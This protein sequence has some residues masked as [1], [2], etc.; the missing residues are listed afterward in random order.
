MAEGARLLSECTPIRCTEGSNPSL[1]AT[2]MKKLS[3][4]QTTT[5]NK[6][7]PLT[8]ITKVDILFKDISTFLKSYMA[9]VNQGGLFI[10]TDSPLPI[11][12]TVFLK[13]NL[14]NSSQPIEA[15]GRV[16][17]TNL[18]SE[19]S[20]FPKGMGVKFVKMKQ[21]DSDRIISLTGNNN[22]EAENLSI[23]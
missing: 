2:V 1:S 15:E 7:I 21:E 13:I 14:P 4:P 19:K 8:G 12:S 16:V 9:H 10:K 18:Y 3:M 23:L 11:D 20:Y 5:M 17:L 22:I 6:R